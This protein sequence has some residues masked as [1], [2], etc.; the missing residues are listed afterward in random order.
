MPRNFK[1]TNLFRL[2]RNIFSKYFENS[3]I[4]FSTEKGTK[5]LTRMLRKKYGQDFDF[6]YVRVYKN[7]TVYILLTEEEILSYKEGVMFKLPGIK[8]ECVNIDRI[9]NVAVLEIK[10]QALFL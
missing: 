1:M 7:R 3:N 8:L 10:K 9:F 6:T 2:F 5:I 4:D